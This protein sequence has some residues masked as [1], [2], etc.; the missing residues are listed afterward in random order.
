MLDPNSHVSS[1]KHVATR[2]LFPGIVFLHR[3]IGAQLCAAPMLRC[4]PVNQKNPA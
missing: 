2:A 1:V 3:Y 4:T